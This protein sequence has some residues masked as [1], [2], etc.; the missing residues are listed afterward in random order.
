MKK[1]M[2]IILMSSLLMSCGKKEDNES[3]S[4]ISL[5]YELSS[6]GCSTGTHVFTGSNQQAT[7]LKVCNALYDDKTNNYCAW[8]LRSMKIKT[9]C[10]TPEQLSYKN[11]LCMSTM[12]EKLHYTEYSTL[13]NKEKL[14]S[15]CNEQNVFHQDCVNFITSKL[16]IYEYDRKEGLQDVFQ[17]CQGWNVKVQKCLVEALE[18]VDP[19]QYSTQREM[20]KILETCKE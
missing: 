15:I 20:N 9:E 10:E 14:I 7:Q 5:Q 19:R 12:K 13:S 11:S 2:S 4:N 1:I 8:N 3:E 17:M 6:N 18:G 16:S